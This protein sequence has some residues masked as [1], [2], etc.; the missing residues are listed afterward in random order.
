[1]GLLAIINIADPIERTTMQAR[2]S[3]QIPCPRLDGVNEYRYFTPHR[4]DLSQ[5]ASDYCI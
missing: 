3:V 4:L 5:I 2:G 1:M